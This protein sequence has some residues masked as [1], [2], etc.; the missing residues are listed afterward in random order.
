MKERKNERTNER[1]KE[2]RE[3]LA[4]KQTKKAYKTSLQLC[5]ALCHPL[6][7]VKLH[8]YFTKVVSKFI[9]NRAKIVLA[10]SSSF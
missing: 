2:Q 4:T 8:V 5:I 3:S 7:V 1:T 9:V 6:V 10:V